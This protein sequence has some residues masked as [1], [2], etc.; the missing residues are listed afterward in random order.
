MCILSA[1]QHKVYNAGGSAYM[2]PGQ[3]P[4]YPLGFMFHFNVGYLDKLA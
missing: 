1:R 4:S 2:A 3:L